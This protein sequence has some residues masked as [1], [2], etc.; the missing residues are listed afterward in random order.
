MNKQN[1]VIRFDVT[2]MPPQEIDSFYDH[3]DGYAFLTDIILDPKTHKM[4]YIRAFFNE[5][6]N[7]EQLIAGFNGVKYTDITGTNLLNQ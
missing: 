2:S 4:I 5:N 6:C 3:I 1:K 7:V